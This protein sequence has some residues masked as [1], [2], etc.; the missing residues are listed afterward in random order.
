MTEVTADQR[1]HIHR[2]VWR[3]K[4]VLREVY[5]HLYRKIVGACQPGLTIEVGGGSG[6]L[7]DYLPNVLSFDIVAAPWLDFV[8]DAQAL[9]IRSRS[10]ANIVMFD[11]LHHV[12]FPV[13]FLREAERVLVPGGRVVM[14]EPGITPLSWPFYRYLHHEPVVSTVDPLADGEPDP[15]KDPY[16][17]NQAIP[18]L[19]VTREAQRLAQLF[20]NFQAA[21]IEWLSLFA[22]PLSGG[23]KRWGL[24]TPAMARVLLGVE[25]VIAPA[26][27]RA[28]A[29]R[30]LTVLEKVR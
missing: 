16:V 19:L 6:N 26:I 11:V 10:V 29:F 7:K 5:R 27:G 17:G 20:P 1:Q 23:F 12:Q 8:A 9:P 4:P 15:T 30:L 24:L 14:L 25:D 2:D 21:R 3:A 18:T 28:C 22:Y 13:R